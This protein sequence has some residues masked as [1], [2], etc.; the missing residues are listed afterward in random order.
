MVKC[1]KIWVSLVI[2][3]GPQRREA[4]FID[5]PSKKLLR[6]NNKVDKVFILLHHITKQLHVIRN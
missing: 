5:V 2:D 4:S 1:I 6:H 3:C